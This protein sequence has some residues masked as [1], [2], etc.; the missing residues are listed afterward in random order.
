MKRFYFFVVAML[1]ALVSFSLIGCDPDD[2]GKVP[3]DPDDST[4][5]TTPQLNITLEGDLQIDPQGGDYQFEYELLNEVSGGTIGV[6]LEEGCDWITD[7]NYNVKGVVTFTVPSNESGADR[8]TVVTVTY[9]YD[10]DKTVQDAINIVQALYET[11]VVYDY[12]LDAEYQSG[13][14]YGTQFGLNG[15]HNYYTWLSSLPFDDAGY[16]QPGGTYYLFD[17][18][19]PAPEDENDP[20]IPTGTYTLGEFGATDEFTFTPDYSMGMALSEDGSMRTMDVTFAEG[21]LE[22]SEEGGN[23]V[24]DAKLTDNEGKM[25][26]VTY[27][28]PATYD[29]EGGS[30][31][32]YSVIEN[33]LTVDIT[34]AVAG[35]VADESGV[36]NV[37][38][39]LTD[40]PVDSE[41]YVTPPGT[42]VSL[43]AY[44]PFD[45]NGYIEAGTYNVNFDMTE[46]TLYPGEMMDFF[47][48]LLPMGTYAEYY[49][50]AGNAYYGFITSGSVEISGSAGYYDIDLKLVTEQG[51][52]ITGSYS[53]PLTVQDIPGPFS[54][55]TD[56][57]T[58]DLSKAEGSGTFYGDWYST[59]GGNWY[60]VLRPSDGITGDGLQVDL[61]GSSL[62]FDAGVPTGIY[63]AASSDYPNPSEY[64]VGYNNS[65]SLG[66]TMFLGGFDAQGY[67]SEFA[68]ATEGNLEVTNH[69]DGTYTLK[70]SFLDDL[71]HT[72]EGEWTGAISFTDAG[73]SMYSTQARTYSDYRRGAVNMKQKADL[74]MENKLKAAEVTT[75]TKAVSR[76]VVR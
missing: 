67:V 5:V 63:T 29:V 55:L 72:W 35:Y 31:V 10:E 58:L 23:Y 14:Y 3:P 16:T 1:M 47:G 57:Y 20:K 7:L 40:M 33:D 46:G 69:G 44:M 37:S 17:I 6:S 65:G 54:T 56:D 38:I 43:D 4:E 49:D 41:G 51:Y 50:E 48:M 2:T 32:G 68:P 42:I 60:F 8:S 22:V 34:T 52:N 61:V 12:E 76:K 15:E 71:G 24:F 28:G 18:F 25:H 36:M 30:D 53:G 75:P 39:N 59:G 9:T 26:H 27:T 45:E 74:L 73:S 19:A 66:G 13:Y 21:T 11:P 62:D 64:L 70:F